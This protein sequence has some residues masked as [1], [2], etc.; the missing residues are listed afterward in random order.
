M[1]RSIRDNGDETRVIVFIEEVTNN[2][3][4]NLPKNVTLF[5]K[6]RLE[7]TYPSFFNQITT[8]SY[9]EKL[10]AQTP[11]LIKYCF[12]YEEANR[13][14]YIDAD[15]Y[16]L[17]DFSQIIKQFEEQVFLTTH[18]FSFGLE[19]LLTKGKYNVGIVSFNRDAQSLITL[20]WWFERCLESTTTEHG[21]KVFGDQKY[22]DDFYLLGA[23]IR[24][25]PGKKF[26]AAP[27]N[28]EKFRLRNS[29][30]VN[31]SNQTELIAIH[32]SGLRKYRRFAILSFSYYGKRP[33][34][35]VKDL[36]Y[37]PYVNQLTNIEREVFGKN[38]SDF[39]GR[40]IRLWIRSICKRDFILY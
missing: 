13:A 2:L 11:L 3:T 9:L 8:R 27:W 15:V 21:N 30:V 33:H 26:C 36:I 31:Q 18:D 19:S 37:R 40:N 39:R 10:Y 32:F 23:E 38:L 4:D 34:S 25:L 35:S 16:F 22:L 20:N 14:T 1:I 12:D 17:E 24:D 5:S 6:K 29:R 7:E 28:M